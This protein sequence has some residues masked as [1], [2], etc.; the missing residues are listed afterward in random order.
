MKCSAPKYQHMEQPD[1]TIP[2]S[3]IRTRLCTL[4]ALSFTPRETRE[5]ATTPAQS[6]QSIEADTSKQRHERHAGAKQSGAPSARNPR[7]SGKSRHRVSA[8]RAQTQLLAISASSKAAP[9]SPHCFPLRAETNGASKEAPSPARRGGSEM[10]GAYRRARSRFRL[11]RR[12]L[13]PTT[14]AVRGGARE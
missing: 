2:Q 10:R 3:H 1:K 9:P 6:E 13:R 5:F 12:A 7:P 11:P 8:A 14:R 4:H